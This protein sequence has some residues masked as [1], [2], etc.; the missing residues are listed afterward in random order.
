MKTP[1]FEYTAPETLEEVLEL[2][3][4]HGDEAKIIAGGQSLV[5]LLAMRLARPSLLVDVNGVAA[6]GGIEDRGDVLAFGAIAREREAERSPVVAD[7]APVLAESLP[8]IGHASIRNR[9]TIGGSMVHADACAELPAVAVVT[10]SDMLVRSR[11]GDRVVPADEFFDGHFTTTLADDECL[12]EVRVPT[13]PPGAGWSLQEVA[14]REGDFAMVGV[15]AMVA[16]NGNQAIEAAR[17]CL[18]GVADRAVRARSV[19][20]AL[21][22]ATVSEETFAGAAADAVRDLRPASDLHGSSEYRRHLAGVTVRRALTVAAA[23]AGG[24]S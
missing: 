17:V 24:P 1:P 9:G 12:V 21:V 10:E 2:L 20:A 13:S 16:L 23:R 4:E 14:R 3:A 19:E 18:F 22:G 15:A 5:P 8:F 6:L 7:R 11:G